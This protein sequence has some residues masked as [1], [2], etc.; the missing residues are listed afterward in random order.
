MSKWRNVEVQDDVVRRSFYQ[1]GKMYNQTLQDVEP[2]LERNRLLRSERSGS[3]KFKKATFAKHL[4]HAASI[5]TA[6][7]LQM[8]NGQCCTDGKSYNLQSDDSDERR[9]AFLHIQL[10]HPEFMVVGGK[11]FG[12]NVK[13]L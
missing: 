2:Y 3:D 11:V 5:P 12:N 9:R 7:V 13:W 1:D 4:M 8:K 10:C 6:C